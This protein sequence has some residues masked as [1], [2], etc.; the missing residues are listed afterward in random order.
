M[1]ED[2]VRVPYNQIK[3]I[4]P[5]DLDST[6]ALEAGFDNYVATYDH[7]TG[8]FTWAVAGGGL[9]NI[10]EDLTPQLGGDLDLNGK[11]IDFP[12]TANISDCLDED[13]MASDSATKLATQQSIKKYV[14]DNA[15][16]LT[17]VGTATYST[18][19]TKTISGLSPGK[20]Y[21]AVMIWE[22]VTNITFV[23]IRFNVD[24]GNNYNDHYI[25]T[26]NTSLGAG[27][28][29]GVSGIVPIPSYQ[30]VVGEPG[31]LEFTFG[32]KPGDNTI[33][34]VSGHFFGND[35]TPLIEATFGGTYDGASNLSSITILENGGGGTMTGKLV[36][37][38]LGDF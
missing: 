4:R 19:T 34:L 22:S 26:S 20:L 8:K 11:N 38:E 3:S 14:D 29:T 21:K 31:I 13:D 27:Q 24:S 6:N 18:D 23:K 7:A 10:V 30:V 33:V 17:V 15:G 35:S 37:Y 1:A 32:T 5:D 28:H 9:S 36:I 12:S 16:G 2:Y 25:Q